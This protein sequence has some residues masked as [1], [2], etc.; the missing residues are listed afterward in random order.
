[1]KV[2]ILQYAYH[3]NGIGGAPFDVVLFRALEGTNMLAIVFEEPNHVAV[4]DVDKLVRGDI[5]FLSNSWRGDM[6]EPY[7]RRG[8]ALVRAHVESEGNGSKE[9]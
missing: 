6:F 9:Q 1:M 8:I 7:L 2:D 3:R 4:L 5:A